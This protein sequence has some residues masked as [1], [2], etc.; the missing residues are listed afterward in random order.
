[1]RILAVDPGTRRVGLALSDEDGAIA[2][3]HSTVERTSKADAI[4]KVVAVARAES[5]GSIV[6]GLPLRLDGS[7]GPEAKR[8]R[9][10]ADAIGRESGLPVVLVDERFTSTQAER[11][12]DVM[13]VSQRERRGKVDQMA[14]AILLQGY[15]DRE[16]RDR[17]H[18]G[19]GEHEDGA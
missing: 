5:V 2:T 16:A 11:A 12:L 19:D 8:A 10:L 6:V 17:G 9:E 15:L 13:G 18:H 7:E 4:R 14:A 3:P 1:M